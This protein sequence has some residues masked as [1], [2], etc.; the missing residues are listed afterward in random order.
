MGQAL[1]RAWHRAWHAFADAAGRFL[2]EVGFRVVLAFNVL[3][4]RV[5]L[6]AERRWWNRAA[7]TPV[8]IDVF[9][10]TD[11]RLI[12]S[13]LVWPALESPPHDASRDH[14]E[15]VE[16]VIQA[17]SRGAADRAWSMRY[18]VDGGLT[19]NPDREVWT[20]TDGYAYDGERLRAYSRGGG[21]HSK[22]PNVPE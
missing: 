16:V 5:P 17:I 15:R 19:W 8:L 14:R 4:G 2:D 20:A 18:E 6:R 7:E 11:D 21:V 3:A 22:C 10:W 13:V 1:I 12:F 9:D